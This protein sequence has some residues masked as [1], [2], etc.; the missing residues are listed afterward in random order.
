MNY[1]LC[2]LILFS[3][4]LSIAEVSKRPTAN[5]KRIGKNGKVKPVISRHRG[6]QFNK[7]KITKDTELI[8]CMIGQI[9]DIDWVDGDFSGSVG[10]PILEG[11]SNFFISDN[12]CT[13]NS[14]PCSFKIN[15]TPTAEALETV[16]LKLTWLPC[17]SCAPQVIT[18]DIEGLGLK[19]KKCPECTSNTPGSIIKNDNRTLTEEVSIQGTDFSMFYTSEFTE[20]FY[21][22]YNNA[23]AISHYN[24]EAWSVSAVHY[25]ASVDENLFLG[26]GSVLKKKAIITPSG[27]YLVVD[28]DNVYVFNSTGKHLQTKS[29]LTGYVKYSFT[30]TTGNKLSKITDSYGK[31]TT[32]SRNVAGQLTSITSPYGQTTTVTTNAHGFINDFTNE[33]SE[34]YEIEYYEDTALI[35]LFIKPNGHESV[36]DYNNTNHL[37]YAGYPAGNFW[38][39]FFTY[40][41]INTITEKFSATELLT[42]LRNDR[43]NLGNYVRSETTP[44]GFITEYEEGDDRS[45]IKSNSFESSSSSTTNDERFGDSLKRPLVST[46]T[47]N[48]STKTTTYSQTA[49]L[50]SSTD[51]YSYTQ[52]VNSTNVNG[53][54]TTNTFVKATNTSTTVDPMGVQTIMVLDTFERPVSIKL[55]TDTAKT[56]SYD[57]NGRISQTTQNGQ[58]TF[59]YAYGS[60][61]K[62]SSSTNILNETTS[63]TYDDAGRPET[64]TL[65]DS[66]VISYE[67]NSDGQI[68]KVTPPGRP[69]HNFLFNAF[70]LLS[71]YLPPSMSLPNPNTTYG[72]NLDKK[73]TLMTRPDGNV[74][75]YNYDSSTGLLTDLW[76]NST[77]SQ[78][79]VYYPATEKAQFIT[80]PDGLKT[81]FTYFGLD[82]IASEKQV[83]GIVQ[84]K[85]SYLYDN[86]FRPTT[87]NVV[88]PP[89][90]TSSVK[91]IYRADGQPSKVGDLNMEYDSLSGRLTDTTFGNIKDFRTYD[92]YGNLATYTAKNTSTNAILYSYTLTRDAIHRITGKTESIQGVTTTYGYVFD[93]AGR[94]ITVTK[95]GLPE[96]SYV[97]DSNSNRTSGIVNGT[98]FTTTYDDQDRMLTFNNFTFDYSDNGDLIEKTDGTNSQVLA[99]DEMSR[100]KSVVLNGVDTLEYRLDWAGRRIERKLNAARTNGFAYDGPYTLAADKNNLTGAIRD[101][102]TAT[103]PNSVDMVKA[104]LIYYR[105]L[106][107]HLG[108]PRLL[109]H[110]KTAAV[111]QRMDYNEWGDVTN[112]TNP[113][114]QKF[115]FAGGL[116]D[117]QTK[118][119]KF[120]AREYDGS[121]G[122]WL[123]KDPIR[124]EGGDS[125]LYGYVLQDPV[126]FNDPS[127]H[128]QAIPEGNGGFGGSGAAYSGGSGTAIA[129]A[130]AL[131]CTF[132]KQD[133]KLTDGE[134][135]ELKKRGFDIHEIKENNGSSKAD[136]FKGPNG[137]IMIKPKNG[138]GS[139]EPTGI[140][141]NDIMGIK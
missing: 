37:A 18:F 124:F 21:T 23:F 7:R 79:Y 6:K 55:G 81:E 76:Y 137:E 47:I 101:Y 141:I 99:W 46:E 75:T 129:T 67:Y 59:D 53:N 35:E 1:I 44:F 111:I 97:Y 68:T 72:Y 103:T 140:N 9:C 54:T 26:T 102:I 15:Y 19:F 110:F 5:W 52:I 25:Y 120:G 50:S 56:I 112:D 122:R 38:E 77:Q 69:A 40:D 66:R 65:P 80:S 42:T 71:S 61:G 117:H 64:V 43:D 41:G 94:L 139:G 45:Q 33:N 27:Q 22:P 12:N 128:L 123:S 109:V 20:E 115:G 3:S 39:F 31:E 58:N 127:G 82:R 2:L 92:T 118:L 83:N 84:A 107:D 91:T 133:R 49:N 70:E 85:V 131:T 121:T 34:T 108:S 24:P 60:D 116:Y 87:R 106:K 32:F 10:N 136:L 51:P 62:L 73:M 29:V 88:I 11:S 125:N 90:Y 135:K 138:N 36:F 113:G 104:G 126:N 63:Y 130:A 96:S 93:S 4:G 134:I 74:L 17:S 89:S 16:T 132:S 98:P 119:V 28:G 114:F 86:F 48:G 105:V 8:E 57:L 100:L 95:N 13:L 14:P 78:N 30:Y